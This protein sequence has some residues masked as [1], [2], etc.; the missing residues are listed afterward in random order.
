MIFVAHAGLRRRANC[1]TGFLSDCPRRVFLDFRLSLCLLALG[2]SLKEAR[3]HLPAKAF[4]N[5]AFLFS[6]ECCEART[7]KND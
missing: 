4:V 3:L 2:Q 7:S 1:E 6:G 5:L